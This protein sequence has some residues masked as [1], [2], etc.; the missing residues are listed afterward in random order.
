MWPEVISLE[1]IGNEAG[2][3]PL[4]CS[5]REKGPVVNNRFDAKI[6]IVDD[7]PDNR[8]LLGRRLRRLGYVHLDMAVDGI[9][10]LDML[11]AHS[12][13]VVLLDIMMPRLDGIG[14]LTRL[15]QDNRLEK[16]AVIMISAA[17]ELDTVVQCIELGAEDYLPKPFNPILLRARLGSVVDKMILRSEA[18]AHLER[19][20]QELAEARK[21]QLRMVPHHFPVPAANMPV[22]VHA[23]MHPAREVGGDLYDVF[24]AAPGTL[25]I[26]LG[27][28]S[29]KGVP[30]ALFMAR[31]RSLL[32]AAT[33]QFVAITGRVP[34]PAE[35]VEV[36]NDEISKD[37]PDTMFVT[38]FFG[39]FEPQ[40][41]VLRFVNAGHVHP[42]VLNGNGT[43]GRAEVSVLE[44]TSGPPLGVIGG[45]RHR[46]FD[47]TLTPG[48]GLIVLSDGLPEMM[49]D[50]GEFYT[51]ERLEEDFR[52]LG[53]GSPKAVI[54]Q[55]LDRLWAFAGSTPQS[56]D[57][58][59][60]ALRLTS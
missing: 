26:A 35:I 40:T 46:E 28:V 23:A 55:V 6:L 53:G 10:A 41:G 37:N 42:Y 8:D 38:L 30:A 32:R 27:D 21:Q 19:M 25:C 1:R 3:S 45:I 2:A 9:E 22:D 59:A 7:N 39:L 57:V 58:T 20:E 50:T 34:S 60:L 5:R 51:L 17:T 13:D 16:T 12:F 48:D 29:G 49:N 52:E 14:V 54:T 11:A 36:I 18:L 24:E 4:I 47:I 33:L 44:R 31:T 43:N 56:D 15:H